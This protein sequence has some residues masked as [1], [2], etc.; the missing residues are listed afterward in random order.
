IDYSVIAGLKFDIG[1]WDLDISDTRGTNTLRYDIEHT[2][3]ASL[4]ATD[5]V[6]TKF[7]AGSLEFLQN[8]INVDLGRKIDL[9]ATRSLNVAFGG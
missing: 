8:T 7:Y 9:S 5:N 2:G 6:Q 1:E 4:P 3:N